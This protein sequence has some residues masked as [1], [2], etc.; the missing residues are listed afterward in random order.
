MRM[1]CSRP[2]RI[3]LP[4]SAHETESPVN[5]R[6]PRQNCYPVCTKQTL[7]TDSGTTTIHTG[8]EAV[9]RLLDE[10]PVG[11]LDWNE[12][13]TRFRIIDRIIRDCLGWPAA[14]IHLERAEGRHY[15]DY[16]LG[17]PRSVIW[18][19]KRIG[20]PFQLPADA[21]KKVLTDL[22]SLIALDPRVSEALRQVQRYCADRGV[23]LAVAT[24]GRQL[25]AFL[26]TRNDGLPPLQG[27]CLVLRQLPDLLDHFPTVW[28][29]LSPAGVA[30]RRLTRL[31][32]VGE[33]RMIPEKLSVQLPSYP[34]YRY[35]S[36]LQNDLRDLGQL[37]LIDVADQQETEHQFYTQC[38]CESGALSQH[39]LISKRMLKARYDAMFDR[40]HHSPTV[41]PVRTGPN[42]PAFTPDAI[43]LHLRR[44][45]VLIGDVGVGKTSFLKHLMHVSAFEEFRSALY[46][47]I[48]FGSRGALTHSAREFILNEIEQQL[49]ARHKIDVHEN[50]F[51]RGVYHAEISRFKRG[52]F[53][54]LRTTDPTAYENK[55]LEFLQD[56]AQNRNEHLKK[57]VAHIADGRKKQVILVLDNADQ[58]DYDLQQQVFIIAENLAKEWRAAVFVA[59]R[60]RTFYKS[61]QAGS[62]TGYPHRVFTI[63]PPRVDHVIRRRLQFALDIAR[64]RIQSERLTNVN[65]RLENV[66]AFLRALLH[67]LSKNTDLVEFLSNIT[68]GNIRAVID[69]VAG[70]IGS[71]NV[72][73]KKIIDIMEHDGEYIIPLHEF[74]K[75]ALLGEYSYYDPESSL[76][77]NVFD[78]NGANQNEHFLL[79][80]ILGFL[81]SDGNQRTKEG[82]VA[83]A[84][85]INEMQDWSFIVSGTEAALRRAN[86]KKLLETPQRVTFDEEES[87]L[88]GDMP[89][90]FRITTI[91]AYHLRRW[92]SDFAYLDSIAC[93]TPIFDENTLDTLRL[94]IG[95]FHIEHR[96]KRAQAFRVYLEKVWRG[97]KL[98]PDYFD[99]LTVVSRGDQSFARVRRAAGRIS[100]MP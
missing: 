23:D 36:D 95:S 77:L 42:V 4:E 67:S 44:P 12:A 69:F 35:P 22:P 6:A 93:D 98:A 17:T 1:N 86:N 78:V 53:G 52:I 33:D 10:L 68:A 56:K 30:E 14:S 59:V 20:D 29:A 63:A 54:G 34:K 96:L 74:W 16:E 41:K 32:N 37:L 24:N 99:W 85:I 46:I 26:A 51:I 64:G 50:A 49:L 18:E 7:M 81:D 28:Q 40:E 72:N 91:G 83:T 79:P 2:P 15:A 38:Y 25:I 66:A 97:S 82:Y 60:P 43:E 100:Q 48:D 87:G 92:I 61:K 45:V 89:P 9:Q 94:T 57:S 71:A 55:L 90:H 75:A 65:F 70:F 73:T 21:K 11:D 84:D 3:P 58:R 62:L 88:S 39:A 76:A 80:M 5:A 13:D 31:L 47:Y 27:R 19:A 8:K